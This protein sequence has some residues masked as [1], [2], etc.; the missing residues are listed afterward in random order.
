MNKIKREYLVENLHWAGCA[1]KIEVAIDKLD[2][3]NEVSLNYLKKK[4]I[5]ETTQ[6]NE[7]K[8]LAELNRLADKIEPGTIIKKIASDNNSYTFTIENLH[9]AGCGTKVEAALED[10]KLFENISLNFLKKKL[11]IETT[12]ILSGKVLTTTINEV[13]QKVEP[14]VEVFLEDDCQCNELHD[15]HDHSHGHDHSHHD[16]LGKKDLIV[17]AIG[18]I[19]FVI[20]ITVSD[21]ISWKPI[22]MAIG[23]FIVG[24]DVIY[25]A[26]SNIKRGAFLDENFLM[27]IATFGAFAVGE[28]SEAVGV[29]LFYKIGEFFQGRAVDNSRKSIEGLMDIRPDYANVRE[30]KEIKKVNPASVAIGSTIVVKAGEKIPLDGIITKG[31][32]ALDTSALTGE[33]LPRDVQIGDSVLGG[34]VNKNGLLEIETTKNF[35]ESTVSKILQLVEDASSKKPNAE[36]FITKFARIYTPIVVG[37]S[38]LIAVVPSLIYGDFSTWLYRALIFLVISCPCALVV[39]I[40]LSFFSGLGAASKRGI[41]IKG[42]NYLEELNKV[43]TIVFD[44]TGTLTHGTFKVSDVK[45]IALNRDEL[46]EVASAAE[47]HSN[48][49]IAKSI[50]EEF[51]HTISEDDIHDYKELEGKGVSVLYKEDFILAGNHKLMEDNNINFERIDTYGTVVYIARNSEYLGAI[52]ITDTVKNDSAKTI[53]EL[54]KMNISTHMLTGDSDSVAQV[55]GKD[56]GIKNIHSELL[57]QDK[58]THLSRIKAESNGS[59]IFVG[60]GINDAPVLALSDIGVAMGGIGSDAA[61]EAADMVIMTDEP[62][63]IIQGLQVAKLTRSIVMQNIF[64]ALGIKVGV[65]ILGVGGHATMWEAI[66]ADVGVAVMAILNAS[67]IIKK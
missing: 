26:F 9:C 56:L 45:S 19:I 14:G 43:S 31:Y 51:G 42:G 27:T 33:S 52:I 49:P 39:S 48:H 62:S 18:I 46:L 24:W 1:S 66:F 3:I 13:I 36:K 40:P 21:D 15:S 61:I 6:E 22:L 54:T 38:F 2:Y 12:S 7:V 41:L 44:K 53:T 50:I 55:V 17:L 63:K 57:P 58:A 64:L 67:R 37:V 65:M 59:V 23:Y 20:G 29:M 30:G 4:L 28:Y 11:V 34:S 8:L 35:G 60:D 32:A 16:S 25:S 47:K 5:L 10:S